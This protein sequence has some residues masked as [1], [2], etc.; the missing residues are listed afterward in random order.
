MELSC[1]LLEQ[2]QPAGPSLWKSKE[3]E[4]QSEALDRASNASS[5]GGMDINP[6]GKSPGSKSFSTEDLRARK[7][8]E[9]D[10]STEEEV[11]EEL[12]RSTEPE[13]AVQVKVEKQEADVNVRKKPRMDAERNQHLNGGPM[14]ESNSA[15]VSIYFI[16]WDEISCSQAWNQ[17]RYMGTD[18]LK[19]LILLPLCPECCICG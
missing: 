14:P 15:L 13:L 10:L 9:V 12:L 4:S 2:T 17:M 6:N 5:V 18:D 8:K 3:H 7:R 1:S 16:L 11:L 19:L